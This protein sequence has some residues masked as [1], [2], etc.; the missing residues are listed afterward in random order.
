[1][2]QTTALEQATTAAQDL[3]SVLQHPKPSAPFLEFGNEQTTALQRLAEM[4]H[5]SLKPPSSNCS[6]NNNNERSIAPTVPRK[7]AT[8]P[9]RVNE[10]PSTNANIS[11]RK[12]SVTISP[13][14]ITHQISENN[15]IP[16]SPRQ[17]QRLRH[18][19]RRTLLLNL[20]HNPKYKTL[21]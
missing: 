15:D 13:H 17:S 8:Q 16:N 2:P 20:V 11:N 3:I 12:R 19:Q 7:E 4:F 5:H 6:N 18:Q 14:A 1:M 9:P 21:S 10:V